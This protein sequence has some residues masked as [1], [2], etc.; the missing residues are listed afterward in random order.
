MTYGFSIAL[1]LRHRGGQESVICTTFIY[2]RK[3]KRA[4][5]REWQRQHERN[6]PLR[7]DSFFAGCR[8][9]VRARKI[10]T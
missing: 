4:L 7:T 5:V 10:R 1:M 2:G 8:H 3:R 9:I 6:E